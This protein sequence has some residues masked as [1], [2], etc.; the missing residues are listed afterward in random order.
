MDRVNL[1][2]EVV[3][4]IQ[5]LPSKNDSSPVV[6]S[7]MRGNVIYGLYLSRSSFVDFHPQPIGNIAGELEKMILPFR[8][9]AAICS[10]E[11]SR[12]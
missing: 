6:S 2:R 9:V 8:I 4:P 5:S 1:E 7:R 12:G 11:R 10:L 3:G